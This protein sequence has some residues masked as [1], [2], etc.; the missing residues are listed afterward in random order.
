MSEFPLQTGARTDSPLRTPLSPETHE[1]SFQEYYEAHA[2]FVRRNAARLARRAADVEDI[3]QDVFVVAFKRRDAFEARCSPRTWLFGIL[4][5]IL[6]HAGRRSSRRPSHDNADPDALP[7]SSARPD[8]TI[9]Q[10]RE[11]DVLYLLLGE[12]SPRTREVFA[13]SELSELSA[14]EI[15]EALD[16]PLTTVHARLREAR[17]E[18]E[19]AINR[20]HARRGATERLAQTKETARVDFCLERD[21][22]GNTHPG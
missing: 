17:R 19:S 5:H 21:H 16:T 13:L 1:I 20:Y 8:A 15:A 22:T 10:S 9:E 6:M 4:R 14:K 7:T 2:D 18:F 12:L 3:V 11:L